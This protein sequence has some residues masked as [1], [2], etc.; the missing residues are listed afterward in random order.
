[1]DNRFYKACRTRRATSRFRT[2]LALPRLPRFHCQPHARRSARRCAPAI[3]IAALVGGTAQAQAPAPAAPAGDPRNPPVI[4]QAD[5]IRGRPDLETV[6]EGH[7][8]FRR[9]MVSITADRLVYEQAQ[10]LARATGNVRVTKDGNVFSG[11]EAQIR[12][13]D[14]EGYFLQPTYFFE[15]TQAGGTAERF[16]FLGSQRM[17]ATRATYTSCLADGRGSPAWLLS[18][19]RVRL[20][21][22]A[23]E[24]VA[25]GAV[26]RFYGVPILA[27]PVISFPLTDARKSGWLPPSLNI[28][29][30]NGLE[31]QVPY[32]WNIAPQRDAT[33]TPTVITRR[34]AAADVEFRYLEPQFG[35]AVD[36]RLLPYDR[37]SGGSRHALNLRH[38]GDGPLAVRHRARIHR[39]SDDDFW[40][41]FPQ[42]IGSLTPRLLPTD[43]YAERGYARGWGAW[44]TY[45]RVQQW[46]VLQVA[47]TASR[48]VTPYE[49]A[50]QLGARWGAPASGGFE[51]ALETE[52][53][54]FT[55]PAGT[56]N[57]ATRATGSRTHLL[58]S[59]SRPFGTP[60]WSLVP[61][62]AL[63]AAQYDVDQP[64]ADGRTS[65]AR[66]IPTFSVDTAW[67]F[68]RDAQWF[69]RA[70][71]QTLE[72]RLIYVNT[73]FRDQSLLPNFDS[74]PR[75]FNFDSIYTD[76]AFSGIDRVSDAHQLTAGVTTRL[77]D[78]TSGAESMRFGI[79]QRYLLRDQRLT[80][81]G[82][83]TTQRFSDLLLL[84]SANLTPAWGADASLQYNADTQRTVRSILGARWSPGPF[85]TLNARYRYT[86]NLSEQAE[87][88]WQWPVY[89]ARGSAGPSA[90]AT[91]NG[92]W[93]SVGRINY[94][95]RDSRI[96]DSVFGV[97]YDAGCW[98]GRVVAERL[99]TGRS[100]A[101]TRLMLQLEL[102][103]LSRLGSNP[104]NVLKDNIPGYRLL[105][106]ER[107]A[108][109]DPSR[110]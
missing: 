80:P 86:R 58:G 88:G 59:V 31:V 26:L 70:Y 61:R 87:F 60:G 72:P 94:S 91:C 101:T 52:Y 10:D 62:L 28:D 25:E 19:A 7:A 81:D 50:P 67:T 66:A 17:R 83:P 85:R 107:A 97:E 75:D 76:N 8:E 29:N 108:P 34:G 104:L 53:N 15:L 79:V 24:G 44:T 100:E 110:P 9:G 102:V 69:G 109:T 99:S 12:V 14:F 57:P 82:V 89:R 16:D 36:L 45:A 1:M 105:R 47:D 78:P 92:S 6:L 84:G 40:K 2:A 32:Y 46:Q 90:A 98:I 71:R 39:V 37:L 20:D 3:T 13:S 96:T 43:V 38:D 42:R 63:N 93:Y 95:M 48:I 21:L 22:D 73:P 4:L 35:G 18:T 5:Q 49:R 41:D 23:N 74:A 77:I 65:A 64:L 54:R 103:G 55:L 106:D 56:D 51:F 68:E 30:K 27:A 33:I 11:T